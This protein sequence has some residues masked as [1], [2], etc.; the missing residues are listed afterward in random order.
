MKTLGYR[1]GHGSDA[2]R[3]LTWACAANSGQPMGL[4]RYEG[5]VI[6]ALSA[7]PDRRWSFELRTVGGLRSPARPG[8]RIPLARL[9][10]ASM[11]ELQ[12][13][14]RYS[15]RGASRV[16]RFDLR[17]P[18]FRGPE[19]VTIHDVS[20]LR[21][22]DEGVLP[23]WARQTARQAILAICPSV[24]AADEVT[25]VLGVRDAVVVPNGVSNM[26]RLAEPLDA[27]ERQRH[28]L[29]GPFVVHVGGVTER[30]NLVELAGAWRLSAQ[31]MPNVSLALVG[32]PDPRRRAAF[33][34]LPRVRFLGYPS[35]PFVARLMR[36]ALVVVVPSIYEGFGLPALEGMAAGVPVVATAAGALPEVCGSAAILTGADARS[37]HDG[38]CTACTDVAVRRELSAAGPVRA[39]QF[40]W[41]RSAAGHLAAYER[42]FGAPT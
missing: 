6:Q 13:I 19:V 42:A 32:P 35:S 23:E 20:P 26:F 28:G 14:S 40:T 4:Q 7:A 30:K 25:R 9:S 38:I 18:P 34:G 10:R 2:Y 1:R 3:R 22:S 39:A 21:F 11:A 8:V 33:G 31:A 15:Y 5:E 12:A 29:G 36:S 27:L 24:F 16:H 17:L 41:E 37:L